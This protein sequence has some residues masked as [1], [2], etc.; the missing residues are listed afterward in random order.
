MHFCYCFPSGVNRKLAPPLTFSYHYLT[1][2]TRI[3]RLT[4]QLSNFTSLGLVYKVT[5]LL[6]PC[7]CVTA[8]R[9]AYQDMYN[10]THESCMDSSNI[11]YALVTTTKI[12]NTLECG[13]HQL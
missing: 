1:A 3:N 12:N 9:F 7:D 8:R 10:W 2:W 11:D 6:S 5:V 13:K 4:T